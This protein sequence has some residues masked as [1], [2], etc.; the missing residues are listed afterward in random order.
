MFLQRTI[1]VRR[2]I[3]CAAAAAGSSYSTRQKQLFSHKT[4]SLG[5]P[6][7]TNSSLRSF[8]SDEFLRELFARLSCGCAISASRSF[9]G[10]CPCER[11][12]RVFSQLTPSHLTVCTVYQDYCL[13]FSGCTE[14]NSSRGWKWLNIIH[15]IMIII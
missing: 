13:S 12:R 7:T 1:V 3:V 9:A 2:K 11:F 15:Y 6:E 14:K 10:V 5:L 4:P 8:S